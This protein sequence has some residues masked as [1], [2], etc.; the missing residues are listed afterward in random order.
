MRDAVSSLTTGVRR[1]P[2]LAPTTVGA[3]LASGSLIE[4]EAAAT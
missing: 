4:I 2:P 3:A 1:R